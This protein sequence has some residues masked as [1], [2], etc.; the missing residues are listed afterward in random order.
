MPHKRNP[1]KSENLCG[2]ARVLRGYAVTALEDV[3]LWH[4]RDISHSSA[5]RVI[6]A[7]GTIL[8]DYMLERIDFI[9]G[10]LILHP[11]NMLR[12][13]SMSHGLVYS[14]RV[15]LALVA[16]GML[17][18]RAYDLVQRL[19]MQSWADGTDYID[20]LRAEPAV[21]DRLSDE[22]LEACFRP[23]QSYTHIDEI[24][25]RNGLPVAPSPATEEN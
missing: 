6:L 7:D 24:Y 12:S 21:M 4:E 9:V 20:L 22:E 2:L 25:A 5:E 16:R 10:G 11:D 23:E 15:M 17:R 14:Q 13:M 19:A 3:A 8:L 1:V 18:E